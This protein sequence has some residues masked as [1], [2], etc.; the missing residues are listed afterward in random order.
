MTSKSPVRSCQD[1]DETALSYAEIKA[2]C[3]GNPLIAEKMTLDNDVSKLKLL[4]A[5]HQS[6]HY[7]LEDDLL[8]HFPEKIANIKERIAGIE[9]D[10][11]SYNAE[12]EKLEALKTG[13]TTPFPSMT[14]G[15]T[16]YAEK[17]AAA[18]KLLE[19]LVPTN[20]HIDSVI[21][22]YMGFKMTLQTES[23][24]GM[25]EKQFVLKLRGNMTYQTDLG[26]DA[27]GNITR[28]NHTLSSLPDK[29]AGAKSVLEETLK[30]QAAAKEELQTPFSGEA[31]LAAKEARLAELNAELNIDDRGSEGITMT[32]TN[33][34]E[35]EDFEED[36]PQYAYGKRKPSILDNLKNYS[37]KNADLRGFGKGE[38]ER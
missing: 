19:L 38:Q 36:E 23:F 21:G 8:T 3:A 37:S 12:V 6:Q 18:K 34:E 32:V 7:R 11:L 13:D 10:I 14:I 22:E 29:L 9:A 31:E 30:Q 4:K 2:L 20:V 5:E 15:G 28:I 33:D 25:S 17:E 1:I 26:K 27:F 35:T 24:F 16:V